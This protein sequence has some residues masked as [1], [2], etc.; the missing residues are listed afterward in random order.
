LT[1]FV[2]ATILPL[3]LSLEKMRKDQPLQVVSAFGANIPVLG[4][5]TWNLSGADC[6]R[7][8]A[9]AI[10]IG[11]RH[12]DTAAGYRNEDKVGEG[13]R[14]GGVPRKD[15]FITTKVRPEDLDEKAFKASVQNSLK[16]IGVD[17]LDLVLIHWPSQVY[18]VAEIIGTLNAVKR[19][20]WTRH[21][22][23]S[24]F[25][26]KLLAEA[27]AATK[28]P[29]VTNQCEYHPYLNQDKLLAACREKGMIFT[30]YS[31][32]GREIVL[33]DSVIN[34]IAKRK[35]KTPAQVVLRWAVQQDRV[36]TIP[37]SRKDAHIRAN[38]DIFDFAL[39]DV[40]MAAISGLSRMHKHRVA[41]PGSGGPVWDT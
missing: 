5:G 34:D 28:E 38:F 29:L 16:Q 12:I 39:S 17:Q 6:S 41:D 3:R 21:I 10:K 37:K 9:D 22:G 31:P 1:G 35:N 23:V 26:T 13:I 30:A 33:A 32:L 25:P 14:A 24:N 20:G 27:W 40:E 11:Y 8:V 18:S 2:H 36:I 15:L 19:A 7:S 4:F